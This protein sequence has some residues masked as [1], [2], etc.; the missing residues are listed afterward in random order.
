MTKLKSKICFLISFLA[1]SSFLNGLENSFEVAPQ[2]QLENYI[3]VP[4]IENNFEVYGMR[5]TIAVRAGAFYH[6]SKHFRKNY[7]KVSPCYEIEAS[8]SCNPCYAFWANF[9][10][11]NRHGR[12]FGHNCR[13]TIKNCHHCSHHHPS[14]RVHVANFS[15]GIKFPF[16][17]CPCLI[18]YLGVGPSVGGIWIR[19]HTHHNNHERRHNHNHHRIRRHTE[20]RSKAAIGVVAKSGI[21]YY[22][23]PCA[24]IDLFVD[25]LYQ[26]VHFRKQIDIGGLK[27]GGGIGFA[28]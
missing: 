2:A 16:E 12:A 19:N 13:S 14:T 4:E 25:Y 21:N 7:H 9:D 27:A 20:K 23:T 28:F 18:G 15:A 5:S 8:F 3:V 1:A 24:F 22:F 26:P 6:I 17:I 11:F 10:W